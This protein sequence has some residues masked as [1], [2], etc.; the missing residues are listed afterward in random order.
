MSVSHSLDTAAP[1]PPRRKRLRPDDRRRQIIAAAIAYFAEVGFEG[2]TRELARRLGVTQPLIYRYFP[3][4]EDLIRSVYQE[5]YLL[6]WQPDWEYALGDTSRPIRERLVTFYTRF[7]EVVFTPDWIRIYL[8]AGLRGLEINEWWITFVEH[9]LLRRMAE[10]IRQA[11]DLPSPSVHPIGPQE[12]ELYWL[13]HGGIFYYGQ[14]REVYGRQPELGLAEFIAVSVDAL[15]NGAPATLRR[16]LA[17]G[18]PRAPARQ[19]SA[20]DENR[21]TPG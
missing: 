15:L 10:A 9:H 20:V 19:A 1:A 2:G 3:S 13:F 12:L 4:K 16:L 17:R 8:F 18:K 21:V 6:R 11:F 14:R 5:V 7:T